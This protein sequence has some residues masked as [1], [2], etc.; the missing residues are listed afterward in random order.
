M[1]RNQQNLPGRIKW[2]KDQDETKKDRTKDLHPSIM[3]MIKN[4]SETKRDKAGELCKNF[5]SLNNNKLTEV[6][7]SNSTNSLMTQEWETSPLPREF[8]QIFG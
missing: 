2:K 6:S 8:P 4:A 7:T 1:H 5:I 3:S